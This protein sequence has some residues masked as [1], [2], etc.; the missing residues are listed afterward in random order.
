M[1]ESFTPPEDVLPE[2]TQREDYNRADDSTFDNYDDPIN[3]GIADDGI[4]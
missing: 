1:A 2:P 3:Y 4:E